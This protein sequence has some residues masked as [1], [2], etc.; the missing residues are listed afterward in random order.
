MDAI[1]V[2]AGP[3]TGS[4]HLCE[5]LANFPDLAAY[6]GVFAGG[7][8]RGI[9]EAYWP[10]LRRLTGIAFEDAHD[11]R[12]AAFAREQPAAWLDALEQAAAAAGKR[13]LS[14]RLVN[15]ELPAATIDR[16]ILPRRGLRVVMV[17]RKQIDA[18]VSWRKAVELGKGRDVDTTG[19]R[20]TLDADH[21]ARWLD[22]QE[23]WYDHWRNELGRRFMPCPVLRYELDIDQPAERVLR[24]FAAAAAQVGVMLRLP[25]SITHA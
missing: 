12:V 8:V 13:F 21:F 6:P 4:G 24:R 14:F 23:R 10:L 20:L 22:E 15:G 9:D 7:G 2:I 5:L 18:F 19:M 1:G 25:T 11:P 16:D 3:R 17:V